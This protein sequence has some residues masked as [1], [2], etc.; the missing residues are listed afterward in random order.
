MPAEK[1]I[2]LQLVIVI[3]LGGGAQWLAW[4]IRLP[5]ILLLLLFGFLAGPVAR[6]WLPGSILTLDPNA[7]FG[8]KLLLALVS[9]SVA[10]I[11]FEGGLTLNFRELRAT[12]SVV[13][14]LV[15][16]GALVT[17]TIGAAAARLLL[18]LDA[19]PAILLG[20]ILVVTGPTVIV[21]L[22]RHIRP[23]GPVGPVLKWEG[24]VIDPLGA[25]LTVLTF[26]VFVATGGA[27]ASSFVA[28]AVL[29]TVVIG[30]GLGLATAAILAVAV[31]RYWI[32]EF[33]QNA[34]ALFLVAGVFAVSNVAQAE[35]GLLAVTVMGVALANQ[36]WADMTHIREFKENLRVFLISVL[37]I[38]LAARLDVADLRT[39]G[40]LSLVFVAILIVIARPL[41]VFVS[42][43]HSKLNWREK[44]FLAWM[45]PRG[46]VAAAVASVFAIE[47]E[48]AG[49]AGAQLLVPIT[50]LTIVGTVLVYGLT[51]PIL[52]HHL[53]L[54]EA[55][56]QG[57]LIVGAHRLAR[58]LATVLVKH[59]FRVLLVDT[60]RGEVHA[61]K[62]AELPAYHGS[63]LGEDALD[64][65]DLGGLGRLLALT[66]NDEVN[67][68]AVQRFVPIFGRAAVYQ[69]PPREGLKGRVAMDKHLHGRH[70]FRPDA[71]SRHLWDQLTTGAVIKA[72]RLTEEFDFAAF[73]QMYGSTALPLFV[74][75]ESG[76]L[77]VR[78]AADTSTPAPAQTLISLVHE[79]ETTEAK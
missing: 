29:K 23:T 27:H 60:N 14:N 59:K 42:T 43:A 20:A 34:V 41:G 16:L 65:L 40:P 51:A 49:I 45:A 17:W 24:I 11:L 28:L 36:R 79:P 1:L 22:L 63:I 64:N 46:I 30:G 53:R 74:I 5:S 21:P 55:R 25:L 8:E 77:Q 50:F 57:V 62:M 31:A 26:E 10:F 52:A 44:L 12:G 33:L 71:T 69:L 68:L 18:G 67:V 13:R 61:A 35:G 66:P 76:R 78:T 3:A 32:P 15:T 38:L 47:L 4:R 73:Q 72:T 75:T 54:A 19:G 6:H 58:E 48:H 2:L 56:P 9:L 39:L 7:L 37:F 70:L